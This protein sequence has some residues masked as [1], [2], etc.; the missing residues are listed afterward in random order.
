MS[1]GM[2]NL[3]KRI[4][5]FELLLEEMD[6]AKKEAHEILHDLRLEKKIIE[7][8]L[9]TDVKKMVETRVDEVVTTELKQIGPEVRKQ[10]SLIYSKVGTQIDK[11]ID[12][13]MG[14]EFA[15]ANGREDLRPALAAKLREWLREIVDDEVNNDKK[16]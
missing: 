1:E 5:Q 12:I 14:K 9:T 8:L 15:V 13:S 4:V 6:K 3:E 7:K 10:T 11:L 2:S 16:S